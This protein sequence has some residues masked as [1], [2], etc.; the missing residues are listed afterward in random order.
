M[1]A[2]I[3]AVCDR[4]G[5][6]FP[7]GIALGPGAGA[8]VIDSKSGPC[9]RCGDWGSIPN[10]AYRFAQEAER[11]IQPWTPRERESLADEL[12]AA[13]R[14]KERQAAEQVVRNRPD[15]REVAE[16]LLIPRDAAAFWGLVA[17][18]IAL[19]S[20]M[21]HQGGEPDI[22]VTEETIEKGSSQL[23]PS[24]KVSS[25][26]ARSTAES[27]RPPPP[28]RKKHKQAKKRRKRST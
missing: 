11:V 7:S 5:E 20:V 28:P 27:K 1:H 16:R 15:L 6:V 4:C 13:V 14:T 23:A 3:P 12:R 22:R 26:S 2:Q 24:S 21:G 17:V 19:I 25:A 18:L 10:G 8:T 9:P